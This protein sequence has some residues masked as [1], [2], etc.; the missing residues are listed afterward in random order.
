MIRD[1]FSRDDAELNKFAKMGDRLAV[2]TSSVEMAK[3]VDDKSTQD[4]TYVCRASIGTPVDSPKWQIFILDETA[5]YL[6]I[7]WAD[8][9]AKFDNKA[10]DRTSL[11]YI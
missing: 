2:R 11:T 4:I 1:T 7:K 10:S 5:G 3:I 9:D 6:V 8:G